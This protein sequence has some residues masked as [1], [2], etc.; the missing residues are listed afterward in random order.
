MRNPGDRTAVPGPRPRGTLP[1]RAA[2][3]S[4]S[5]PRVSRETSRSE[6]LRRRKRT[7]P[8]SS[9]QPNRAARPHG[10]LRTTG[11]PTPNLSTSRWGRCGGWGSA[12]NREA[13]P[14]PRCDPCRAW[15][16]LVAQTSWVRLFG[17][18]FTGRSHP[19]EVT[20]CPRS[21]SGS[22]RLPCQ[23]TG[24][25]RKARFLLPGSF[26]RECPPEC[27]GFPR[28]HSVAGVGRLSPQ[29]S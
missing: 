10:H 3:G 19:C 24:H 22:D 9:R 14:M 8:R 2:D 1:R 7:L 13:F 15:R 20:P 17:S 25:G 4:V 28:R 26:V 29:R 23:M 5:T 6:G 18:G 11:V 27:P 12:G 21:G 16:P